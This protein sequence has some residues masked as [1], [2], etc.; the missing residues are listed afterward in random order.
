MHQCSSFSSHLSSALFSVSSLWKFHSASS[1]CAKPERARRHDSRML[2]QCR[3]FR[4][5]RLFPLLS[6]RAEWPPIGW[7]K[8]PPQPPRPP[9]LP[10]C[11]F[12]RPP[13]L[14][15]RCRSS[16]SSPGREERNELDNTY[17]KNQA[18]DS[19]E[20]IRSK[21]RSKNH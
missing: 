12:P 17:T 8:W 3:D 15:G 9:P 4:F 11:T 5:S 2:M 14:R 16:A 1:S 6:Q 18:P 7:T 10:R 13:T 19:I 20:N 21:T